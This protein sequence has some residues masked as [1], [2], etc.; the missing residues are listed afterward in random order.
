MQ[1][2]QLPPADAPPMET[3]NPPHRFRDLLQ[4]AI[5]GCPDAAH[6]LHA[7]YSD[8]I[9][10]VVRGR[11]PR[12]LRSK[13]DSIDFAQDVWLSFYRAAPREFESPEHLLAFLTVVA[14]HKV[15]DVTRERAVA[16]KRETPRETPLADFADGQSTQRVFAREATP[17]QMAIS[18]EVWN[19][20]LARESPVNQLVLALLRDGN[21]QQE[22]AQE[23]NLNRRTVQRILQKALNKIPA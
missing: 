8:H 5:D 4:R 6:A 1:A 11:L 18:R 7:K 15:V 21:T 2:I 23:L 20:M 12:T 16:L 22:V 14:R 9:I 10:R 17:S 13:F 3:A 19:G